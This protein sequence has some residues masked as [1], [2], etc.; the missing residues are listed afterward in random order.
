M[1]VF[2]TTGHVWMKGAT[3]DHWD[4]WLMFNPFSA[5]LGKAFI[6]YGISRMKFLGGISPSISAS[7]A[8]CSCF[9]L[10][11]SG[12]IGKQ[13]PIYYETAISDWAKGKFQNSIAAARSQFTSPLCWI[14]RERWN[15][16]A[17]MRVLAPSKKNITCPEFFSI[18][19]QKLALTLPFYAINK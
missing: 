15:L 13:G 6:Q 1:S 7:R 3:R 12:L 19:D 9:S 10:L 17:H 8:F 14:T 11:L 4:E 5:D 18:W 16:H 2:I